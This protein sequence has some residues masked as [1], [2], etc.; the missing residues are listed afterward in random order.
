MS[1]S[2]LCAIPPRI[3]VN[4]LETVKNRLETVKNSLDN[5][6]NCD[7]INAKHNNFLIILN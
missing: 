5:V 2:I 6:G 1:L 4:R 3:R 7:M